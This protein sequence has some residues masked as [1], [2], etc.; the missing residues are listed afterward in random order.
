VKVLAGSCLGMI[1]VFS[2][3]ARPLIDFLQPRDSH[4]R[5]G[6]HRS[7]LWRNGTQR[8]QVHPIFHF[9]GLTVRDCFGMAGPTV[10]LFLLSVMGQVGGGT[11]VGTGS[12]LGQLLLWVS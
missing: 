9:K 6:D 8:L 7:E 10:Q 5:V 3:G 11:M 12:I 1:V 4:H 2:R